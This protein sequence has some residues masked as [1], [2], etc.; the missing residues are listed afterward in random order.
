MDITIY[1]TATCGICHAEMK[2]LDGKDIA[3]TKVLVDEDPA[4]MVDLMNVSGGALGV[5][6]TVIKKADGTEEKIQGFDQRKLTSILF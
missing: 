4:G 5:P 3:Y 1:S 6:F 2:W